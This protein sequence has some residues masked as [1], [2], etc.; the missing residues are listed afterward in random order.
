MKPKCFWSFIFATTVPL[1]IIC[2]W[3][4]LDFLQENKTGLMVNAFIF[5]TLVKGSGKTFYDF[6]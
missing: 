4:G 2:G 5:S 1:N 3:F 6:S